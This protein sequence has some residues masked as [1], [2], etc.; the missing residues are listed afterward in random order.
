MP[1]VFAAVRIDQRGFQGDFDGQRLLV[2]GTRSQ[3]RLHQVAGLLL[4]GLLLSHGVKLDVLL[5][6]QLGP[7][8]EHLAH[9]LFGVQRD[10]KLPMTI[11]A[12]KPKCTDFPRSSDGDVG[13]RM[14]S[15]SAVETQED[16]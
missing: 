16:T 10:A 15:S 4:E 12:S 6:D 14:P 3:I 7:A 1:E 11:A 5:V 8:V 13:V 2:L 9:D